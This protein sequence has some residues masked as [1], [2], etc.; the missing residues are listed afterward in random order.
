MLAVKQHRAR[1]IPR[2]M[3]VTEP[4]AE[5]LST[6]PSKSSFQFCIPVVVPSQEGLSPRCGQF[7]FAVCWSLR[8]YREGGL[9]DKERPPVEID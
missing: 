3:A 1:P 7:H 9:L 6:H 8:L 2:V 5:L 4:V